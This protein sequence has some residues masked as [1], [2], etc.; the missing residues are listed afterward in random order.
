MAW[1]RVAGA[2]AD[3][4]PAPSEPTPEPP[5]T[6][7]F[8]SEAPAPTPPAEV[9]PTQSPAAAPEGPPPASNAFPLP[10]T[11]GETPKRPPQATA[12]KPRTAHPSV[13]APAPAPQQATPLRPTQGLFEEKKPAQP[14]VKST[15]DDE[16]D[17]FKI[18]PV[19]GIGAPSV[20]SF[21]GT[22]KLTRFLGAGI[23][24][25]L[26]PK[27]QLNYYGKATLSYQHYDIYGRLY[28][29]GGGFFLSGGAGYA[30]VEGTMQSS[31]PVPASIPL[32]AGVPS[33]ATYDGKGSV[34]TLMLTTLVGYFYTTSIGFSFGVDAGAQIPIAPSQISFSS[35]ISPKSIET[36]PPSPFFNAKTFKTEADNSVRSTLEKIGRTPL[37]TVNLRIGWIL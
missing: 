6:R 29:F 24:V 5:A 36:L 16:T 4:A 13:E 3:E 37:P 10:P 27:V 12:P 8:P 9:G 31:Y 23:N 28:P 25:G 14:P 19:A 26:I 15:S 21:G 30:T 32:P 2:Q 11:P 1:V 18:G 34:R 35:G 7:T 20:L 22:L 17:H 33:N